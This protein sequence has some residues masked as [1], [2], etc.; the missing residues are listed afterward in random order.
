MPQNLYANKLSKGIFLH[1]AVVNKGAA[2][3]Q[4]HPT[5]NK[6]HIDRAQDLASKTVIAF[7]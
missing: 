4:H 1:E 5:G 6:I 7:Q 3:K 2:V